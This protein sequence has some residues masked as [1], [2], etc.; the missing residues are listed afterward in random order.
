MLSGVD[1]RA[2]ERE[3][4]AN[5]GQSRAAA[6]GGVGKQSGGI[7]GTRPRF[8]SCRRRV[9]FSGKRAMDQALRQAVEEAAR[10]ADVRGA[11]EAIYA[12]LEV[13]IDRRRPRCDASGRCCRFEEFGHR[14]YVTTVELA[15]F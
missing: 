12:E 11:V 7:V 6:D 5:P 2:C 15:T 1:R 14:L 4:A 13:D 3:L 8:A 9:R 10:S